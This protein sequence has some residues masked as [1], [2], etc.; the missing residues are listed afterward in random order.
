MIIKNS[1][2]WAEEGQSINSGE[3]QTSC[4]RGK[5]HQSSQ[6]LRISSGREFK[7]Q[8]P[9]ENSKPCAEQGQNIMYHRYE[10]FRMIQV[11]HF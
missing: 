11:T 1:K 4:G 3:F 5:E 6:L 2:S 10:K 8:S 9:S 7:L